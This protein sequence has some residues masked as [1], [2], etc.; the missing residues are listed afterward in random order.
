MRK[1][2]DDIGSTA[3]IG[4]FDLLI[5]IERLFFVI[6]EPIDDANMCANRYASIAYEPD[7][8]ANPAAGAW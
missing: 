6:F 2:P 8:A 3:K 4:P 5:G 7:R 1:L